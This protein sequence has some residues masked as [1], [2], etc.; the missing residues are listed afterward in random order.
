MKLRRIAS[1]DESIVQLAFWCPGCKMLHAPQIKGPKAWQ[2]DGSME[3]PTF[4]PS[5]LVTWHSGEQR[6]EHRCHSFVRNGV[7][8][9][10]SDCTHEL[11]GKSVPIPELPQRETDSK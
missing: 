1:S 8:E 11:A 4:S 5:I 7:I 6:V 9:F 10:L 2:F 3:L